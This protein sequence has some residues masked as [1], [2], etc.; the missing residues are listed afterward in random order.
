MHKAQSA[1]KSQIAFV[2]RVLEHDPFFYYIAIRT[3]RLKVITPCSTRSKEII[4]K[5]GKVK[6]PRID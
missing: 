2:A 5:K 6:E 1:P 4:L 3:E